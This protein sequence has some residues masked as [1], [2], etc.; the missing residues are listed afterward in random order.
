VSL[1]AWSLAHPQPAAVAQALCKLGGHTPP[2]QPGAAPTLTATLA[3]PM[4]VVQLSSAGVPVNLN[5][6]QARRD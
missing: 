5:L 2:V 1:Q 6:G 3:C 4:G